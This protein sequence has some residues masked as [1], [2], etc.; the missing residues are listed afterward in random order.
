MS[1]TRRPED[2]MRWSLRLYCGHV[3]ERTAHLRY[4]DVERAFRMNSKCTECG[5]DPA[6]IVDA[7]A[8]GLLAEPQRPVR[9]TPARSSPPPTKAA[10]E[11]R[12][13]DLEAELAAL[14]QAG[15]E[16]DGKET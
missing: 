6:T 3:V 14:K 13:A 9:R 1:E 4:I 10:L 11:K 2:L 7:R 8:M 16:K 12:V 5:L 15:T